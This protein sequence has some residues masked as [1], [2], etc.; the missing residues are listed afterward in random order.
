MYTR[1]QFCRN[2]LAWFRLIRKKTYPWTT[3]IIAGCK[4]LYSCG[5]ERDRE[6]VRFM[7]AMIK[8]DFVRVYEFINDLLW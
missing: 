5:I 6:K 4:I 3:L 8:I 2:S 1:I 7:L